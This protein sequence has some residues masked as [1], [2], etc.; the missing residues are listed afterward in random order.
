M[1][2][3]TNLEK[4]AYGYATAQTL[5]SL[6]DQTEWYQAYVYL[7]T[8]V[9]QGVSPDGLIIWQPF[10]DWE[11]EDVLEHIEDGAKS[12]LSS[13]KQVLNLAHKGIVQ[14]SANGALDTNL[15]QLDM[16]LMVEVGFDIEYQKGVGGEYAA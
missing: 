15:T 2:I 14:S 5:S 16:A 6:G 1:S 4:I 11:W 12:I 3:H 10:E 8:C 13:L 7:S 9:G